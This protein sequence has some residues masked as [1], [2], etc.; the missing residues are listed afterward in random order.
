MRTKALLL[1]GLLVCSVG[2]RAAADPAT[3]GG[4]RLAHFGYSGFRKVGPLE[5]GEVTEFS[6]TTQLLWQLSKI[7]QSCLKIAVAVPADGTDLIGS[8]DLPG[9]RE[10]LE[11]TQPGILTMGGEVCGDELSG[12]IRV[13]VRHAD[14]TRAEPPL[15]LSAIAQVYAQPRSAAKRKAMHKEIVARGEAA[16]KKNRADACRECRFEPDSCLIR[17]GLVR[18]DCP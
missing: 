11:E 4:K 6:N 9:G 5:T 7:K 17:R 10:R 12:Q 14:G 1:F 8:A 15:R 18:A 2:S 13:I 3:D 16:A